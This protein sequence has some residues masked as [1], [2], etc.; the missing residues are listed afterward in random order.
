MPDK[1][2]RQ[3]RVLLANEEELDAV[4]AAL[5][6]GGD[7]A[8]KAAVALDFISFETEL[9]MLD[10]LESM[11]SGKL[12]VLPAGGQGPA[13]SVR[14]EVKRMVDVYRQGGVYRSTDTTVPDSLGS[15]R[16]A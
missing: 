16:P 8:E 4:E 10:Q 5:T 15:R 9:D 14:A 1:L 2:L 13:D 7:D 11:L 3:M 6:S 12:S